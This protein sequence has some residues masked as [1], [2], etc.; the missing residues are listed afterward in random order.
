MFFL[1]MALWAA[2]LPTLNDAPPPAKAVL[3]QDAARCR[4]ILKTSLVD[5]YLPACVDPVNGGYFESLRDGKFA[6]TGERF[7]TQ[8]ARQ[9]WFFSTLASNCIEKQT[10]LAAARSG[11][12]FLESHMRDRRH[13]GYFAKVKDDGQPLDTRKHVYL[14]AFALYGLV[15]YHRATGDAQALAA[16]QELFRVL[17]EKAHDRRNGGYV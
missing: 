8:Q 3:Q 4:Q 12:N 13:G 11:Y 9:L 2:D 15:A 1:P 14:N 16:A 17:E 10:A 7:L 6:P 5:F